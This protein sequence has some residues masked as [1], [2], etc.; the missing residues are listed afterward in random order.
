[1]YIIVF[2]D[3]AKLGGAVVSLKG[4]EFLQRDLHRPESWAITNHMKLHKS[5]CQILH[6]G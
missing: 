1:M 3:S 2:V 4:R 5:N 6:L